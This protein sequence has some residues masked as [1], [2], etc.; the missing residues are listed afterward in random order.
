M[1]GMRPSMGTSKVGKALQSPILQNIVRVV[2]TKLA[3]FLVL[4]E[5]EYGRTTLPGVVQACIVSAEK[6]MASRG[7]A[8]GKTV[9]RALGS[10]V[11]SNM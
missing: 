6:E 5:F 2:Q 8:V 1:V 7:T 11:G 3:D 10:Y 9:A 4:L